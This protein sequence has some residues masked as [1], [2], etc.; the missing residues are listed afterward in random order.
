[1]MDGEE[2]EKVK[3][4]LGEMAQLSRISTGGVVDFL[5]RGGMVFAV[6]LPETQIMAIR[7]E[8]EE[9]PNEKPYF[10]L[11]R[12]RR[13]ALDSRGLVLA[14]PFEEGTEKDLALLDGQQRMQWFNRFFLPLREGIKGISEIVHADK[15]RFKIWE[16]EE[17]DFLT[18][19][20]ALESETGRVK[21]VK[22]MEKQYREEMRKELPK[23]G[24]PGEA[25]ERHEGL[26]RK[27]PHGERLKR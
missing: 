2:R 11:Y 27:E 23:R 19:W 20:R 18:I 16:G 21:E 24:I 4:P 14:G 22:K 9:A 15:L 1:M 17:V 13:E 25:A 6:K 12:K 26:G 8:L 7:E 5:D 10:W 3:R